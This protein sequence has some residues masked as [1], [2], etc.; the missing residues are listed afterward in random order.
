MV[1]RR[2]N[3]RELWKSWF[4]SIKQRIKDDIDQQLA[5]ENKENKDELFIILQ[6]ISDDIEYISEI[7]YKFNCPYD[8]KESS[9]WNSSMIN[10]RYGID[11]TTAEDIEKN[12]EHLFGSLLFYARHI[13]L[14]FN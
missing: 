2:F 14:V 8:N 1:D 7:I 12:T 4:Q 13:E 3:S 6:N 11:H 9:G 10:V 5:L